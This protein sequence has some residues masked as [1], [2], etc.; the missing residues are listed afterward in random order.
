MQVRDAHTKYY[1]FDESSG[2]VGHQNV[3][4]VL[5]WN[6]IPHIG[7]LADARGAGAHRFSFPAEYS[8]GAVPSASQFRRGNFDSHGQSNR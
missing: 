6:V 3:T 2:L 5:G 1:F 4:L 7:A 8:A